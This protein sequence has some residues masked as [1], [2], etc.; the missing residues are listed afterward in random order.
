M[1]PTTV[2]PASIA[3]PSPLARLYWLTHE[4]AFESTSHFFESVEYALQQG[5]GWLQY[6][7]KNSTQ[8]D[9]AV[10]NTL[11]QLCRH[12]HSRLIIN[13]H[14]DLA[15]QLGCG[16]HVGKTDCPPTTARQRLP[17]V[18]I[19]ASC[20]QDLARATE[21]Q[22]VCDYVAFGA[23]YPSTTKPHAA[24][25]PLAFLKH[26]RQQ[27]LCPIAVIGGITPPHVPPLLQAGAD[28][29]AVSAVLHDAQQFKITLAAFAS[30]LDRR[31]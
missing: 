11:H 1:R 7:D 18:V 2:K 28:L 10:L 13:D 6:R 14:V 17:N 25:V 23:F 24:Q 29:I 15:A 12:Y 22:T 4:S 19:G 30:Q 21:L 9:L 31:S 26:A 16:L 5:L 8:P 20:Y 3:A 27:L